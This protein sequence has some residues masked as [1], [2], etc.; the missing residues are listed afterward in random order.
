MEI[1]N[2][3]RHKYGAR[4]YFP[5]R[6]DGKPA[7]LTVTKD[8]IVINPNGYKHINAPWLPLEGLRRATGAALT[9]GGFIWNP[10]KDVIT[11]EKF[12][13]Q[14][15][16]LPIAGLLLSF[17]MID[18]GLDWMLGKKGRPLL[19]NLPDTLKDKAYVLPL[20]SIRRLEPL[21]Y[22]TV[23]LDVADG[24]HVPLK[25]NIRDIEEM[26]GAMRM[27][28]NDKPW[29][30]PVDKSRLQGLKFRLTG[31]PKSIIPGEPAPIP[32]SQPA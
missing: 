23:M 19:D 22:G 24:Q 13:L 16:Y 6:M 32:Y 9:L 8:A 27:Y 29:S 30:W 11:H 26:A 4:H 25:M 1:R 3:R 5:V 31:T 14:S 20:D 18:V 10:F 21:H 7:L 17:Q 12:E 2:D 28:R 15:L